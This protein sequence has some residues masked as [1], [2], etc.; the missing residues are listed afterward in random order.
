MPQAVDW[1]QFWDI[2]L[3]KNLLIISLVYNMADEKNSSEFYA[4]YYRQPALR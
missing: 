3:G 2:G 4:L 1:G